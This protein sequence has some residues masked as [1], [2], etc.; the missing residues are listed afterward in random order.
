MLQQGLNTKY[1]PEDSV[2]FADD[3]QDDVLT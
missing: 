2:A 1:G 3:D